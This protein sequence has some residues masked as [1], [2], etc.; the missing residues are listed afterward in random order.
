MTKT[1]K[2]GDVVTCCN[3]GSIL[4]DVPADDCVGGVG[5]THICPTWIKTPH[6][7]GD[8]KAFL[9]LMDGASERTIRDIL[10]CY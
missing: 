4:T 7:L 8:S 10:G 9:A 5:Y 6:P 3:C 2:F 1:V